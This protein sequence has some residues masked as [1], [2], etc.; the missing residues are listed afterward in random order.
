MVGQAIGI[1]ATALHHQLPDAYA[2]ADKET[3]IELFAQR[4]AVSGT[5]ES[6]ALVRHVEQ[7]AYVLQL[8]EIDRPVRMYREEKASQSG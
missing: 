6:R 4:R 3:A 7:I 8:I 5:Q 1:Q 2:H